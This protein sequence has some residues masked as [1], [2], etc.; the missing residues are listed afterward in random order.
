MMLR[1]AANIIFI[2]LYLRLYCLL[3]YASLTHNRIQLSLT[4]CQSLRWLELYVLVSDGPMIYGY[5]LIQK[6]S[7]VVII[8]AIITL[9]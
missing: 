5:S 4:V 9:K 7:S 3:L 1:K 6:Y 8:N 2:I